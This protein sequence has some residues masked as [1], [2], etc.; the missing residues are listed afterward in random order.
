VPFSFSAHIECLSCLNSFFD[1]PDSLRGV[2]KIKDY[3]SDAKKKNS[4]TIFKDYLSAQEPKFRKGLTNLHKLIKALMPDA[5]ES[6]SYGVHCFKHIYM[7]VGIG[8]NKDFVSLYSMS[9]SLIKKMKE[10]LKGYKVSGATIHFNPE[11][12]LPKEL[13][14]SIVMRRKKENEDTSL[15][16]KKTK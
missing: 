2:F 5:E 11:E 6:F 10:E 7:L 1:L 16:R 3:M 14:T 13:I 9:P 4:P 15:A 12:P 8:A